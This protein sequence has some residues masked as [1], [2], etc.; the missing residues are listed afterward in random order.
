MPADFRVKIR[1]YR[2]GLGDCFLI[3]LPRADGSNYFI[4]IDC[5]VVLG[6]ANAQTEM[7]KVVSD[8]A[9]V[10]G[11]KLHLLLATHE[12]WDHLSGFL[13]ASAQWTGITVDSVW[14]AWTEDPT[15]ELAKQLAGERHQALASLRLAVE[16]LQLAGDTDK[17]QATSSLLEFAGD[18][19]GENTTAAALD[20]VRKLSPNVRY[21]RPDDPPVEL[22]DP[23]VRLY[24]M[25]PPRDPHLIRKILPSGSSETYARAFA[26]ME[27]DLDP[28][29]TADTP[30]APFSALYTIPVAVAQQMTFFGGMYWGA[31][32]WRGIDAAWLGDSFQIALQLD[33]ATNNTCLVLALE[34]ENGDVLLFPG[35]AQVGNWESWQ[36]LT[37]NVAD[38]TVSGP[39]L[40]KRTIMYKV[41]HHGS[42]NA[43]LKEHGLE[44]M[45]SLDVA[46]VPV[47]HQMAL[48][49]HWD[50]MPLPELLDALKTKARAGVVRADEEIPAVAPLDA[51]TDL[52]YEIKL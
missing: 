36:S 45:T 50:N 13:Q 46:M 41:G 28:V 38:G 16:R 5:G 32:S 49:K 3:T 25:G 17:A 35:D 34:L 27:G 52:Y 23:H 21:C 44:T 2:Q 7:T 12:H 37:W 18:G 14:L 33:S 24:V 31:D 22:N 4:L 30:E 26:A 9:A 10:T 43:T 42:F 40:L 39:D 1:M 19:Q 20:R 6:T 48:Q 8:V 15:D 11:G 47:N 51:A 29:L